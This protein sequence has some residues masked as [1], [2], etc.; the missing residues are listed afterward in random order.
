[1][2]PPRIITTP[3][4][5]FLFLLVLPSERPPIGFGGGRRL[6]RIIMGSSWENC[7]R[8]DSPG[9][10]KDGV[11]VGGGGGVEF[12]LVSDP[13]RKHSSEGV[14]LFEGTEQSRCRRPK[15]VVS[16]C[17]CQNCQGRGERCTPQGQRLLCLPGFN[18]VIRQPP[19]F[20]DWWTE[21]LCP[22]KV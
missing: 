2:Y 14:G 21:S 22:L 15:P 17:R 6:C 12:G 5:P 10:K 13:S 11:G 4:F 8:K 9:K 1:M 19:L 20:S 7:P 3:P 18:A 16:L